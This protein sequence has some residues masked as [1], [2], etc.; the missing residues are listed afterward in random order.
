M[1]KK[2]VYRWYFQYPSEHTWEPSGYPLEDEAA[3]KRAGAMRKS[4]LKWK[5]V[6]E[7]TTY[8]DVKP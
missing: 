1:K 6:R 5:L 8:E 2:I 7:T 3:A 4:D